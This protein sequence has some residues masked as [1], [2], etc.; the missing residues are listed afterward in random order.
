VQGPSGRSA[1]TSSE[2]GGRCTTPIIANARQAPTRPTQS[3]PPKHSSG[4]GGVGR[5][6][7]SCRPAVGVPRRVYPVSGFVA[8]TSGESRYSLQTSSTSRLLWAAKR[9]SRSHGSSA[10]RFAARK[11]QTCEVDE[12]V[13][14]QI[15]AR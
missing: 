5:S 11:I 15:P 1:R 4:I 6:N 3:P 14:L 12:S 9:L 10:G 8:S 2:P 13:R 7:R